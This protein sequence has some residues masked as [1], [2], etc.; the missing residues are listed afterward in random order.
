MILAVTNCPLQ[1]MKLSPV[2][3]RHTTHFGYRLSLKLHMDS[4]VEVYAL[5]GMVCMYVC[6]VASGNVISIIKHSC[7][8]V[9]APDMLN[10]IVV[11]AMHSCSK[12]M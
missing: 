1:M 3:P 12:R 9:C 7:L 4:A 5:S 11:V 2:P 10:L 6:H 8:L